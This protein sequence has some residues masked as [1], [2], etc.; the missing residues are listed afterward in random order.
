MVQLI[1][2]SI[3]KGY[4]WKRSSGIR[5][6]LFSGGLTQHVLCV[7]LGGL[8]LLL[9]EVEKAWLRRQEG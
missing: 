9:I 4:L 5:Q 8:M 1:Y 7:G 2:L 3:R 6:S